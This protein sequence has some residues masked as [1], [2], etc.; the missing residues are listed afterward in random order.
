MNVD[1]EQQKEILQILFDDFPWVTNKS[2]QKILALI[3]ESPQRTIGNLIYL[4]KHGLIEDA[5]EIILRGDYQSGVEA[6]IKQIQSFGDEV[7]PGDIQK[8]SD[9]S[10]LVG[11]ARYMWP[12]LTEKGIDFLLG[13][14]GITSILNIHRVR[15]EESSLKLLS[16]TLIELAASSKE[17]RQPLIEKLMDAPVEGLKEYV[18]DLVKEGL[19][20][21]ELAKK[22]AAYI[23]KAAGVALV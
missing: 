16:T 8:D 21:G 23:M 6:N 5:A 17:N 14:E 15:I 11:S 7:E 1:R 12:Q 3:K 2:R 13:D 19:S 4:Q 9:G 18:K 20:S 10:Y 22:A